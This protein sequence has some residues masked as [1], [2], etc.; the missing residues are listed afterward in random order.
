MITQTTKLNLIP[1]SNPILIH[2]DQYDEGTGRLIFKL[3]DN[4]LEYTPVG[5][6]VAIQGMKP[7]RKGFEYP[8]TISGNVVTADLTKQMTAVYG[9]VRT[10]IVVTESDGRIGSFAFIIDV[11]KSA[12]PD[13]S[14]IS[15]S[16]YSIIEQA[17][18][19]AVGASLDSEAWAVGERNGVP[20]LPTDPTYHNNA[21]Y[22]AQIASQYAQG[23]MHYKG[24]IT[25]A[26]L[27]V[28]GMI[29]GDLYNISD[30]FTTD[31]RFVEGAGIECAAGTNVA[32]KA[33]DSKWDLFTVP[34]VG[35]LTDLSDVDI[36]N[37]QDGQA[38]VY[39]ALNQ[40]YVN[41]DISGSGDYVGLYGETEIDSATDLS[42]ITT[43]GNYYKTNGS[44]SVTNFPSGYS[45][46]TGTSNFRL[47]VEKMG[48]DTSSDIKQTY[49]L[50]NKIE[51][52]FVRQYKSGSWGSWQRILTSMST[53]DNLY[54]VE[55]TSP[56]E[57]QALLFDS[58][59]KIVNG[60]VS[61]GG[62]DYMGLYGMTEIQSSDGQGTTFLDLKNYTTVGNYYCDGKAQISLSHY[63][64]IGTSGITSIT[65]SNA[66][67]LLYV[68]QLPYDYLLQ[69]LYFVDTSFELVRHLH[70][71]ARKS[72]GV[73]TFDGSWR[74]DIETGNIASFAD[75]IKLNGSIADVSV[76]SAA[77]G[78]VLVRSNVN[79]QW[80]NRPINK[81]SSFAVSLTGWTSDTTS[82]SGTTLYKKQIT[83]NHVY[84]ESPTVDIG[85]SGVLPTVAEQEAYN[86]LQYVT[87][88]DTVPCLYLYASAI[89]TTAFYIS[90]KGVD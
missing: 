46:V 62:G 49:V 27:P 11:Q 15:E 13:N 80:V 43:I 33:D 40:K 58:N 9:H 64:T 89:P 45:A 39:D 84:V 18:Q 69:D 37:P 35:A 68:R 6:T 20:V 60:N 30:D 2:V 4:D 7:D 44:I 73:Y 71:K 34:L 26:Q 14:D 57:G 86:L 50:I 77:V 36:N 48:D 83:L 55:L 3:Y 16:E 79:S 1:E 61:G 67:F 56:T 10:Q 53:I 65:V 59:G 38:I 22:W 8:C 70:R 72:N 42:S 87:V 54:D 12:L 32:W 24:T 29:D 47:L 78:D 90:V 31:N 21:E 81:V 5:A 82:Q 52:T 66:H 51:Y 63:N 19:E 85:S 28:T 88:D 17:V 76:A 74:M 23:G 41:G 75:P 25:F